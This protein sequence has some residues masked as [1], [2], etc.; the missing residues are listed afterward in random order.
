MLYSQKCSTAKRPIEQNDV[1]AREPKMAGTV[2]FSYLFSARRSR[3]ADRWNGLSR[4]SLARPH[5]RMRPMRAASTTKASG[6]QGVGRSR[7]CAA[8][9]QV[10][11]AALLVLPTEAAV[12]ERAVVLEIDGV[13]GP[14]I[15]DYFARG[16]HDLKPSDTRLVVLRMNTPG[17][18]RY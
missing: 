2:T 5:D 7:W 16:F 9:M 10:G 8:S 13:I 18:P 17:W 4:R 6:R 12:A 14:A 15:A 11:M 3:L 1:P